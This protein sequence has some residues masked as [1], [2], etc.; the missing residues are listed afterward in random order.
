MQYTKCTNKR[1][2]KSVILPNFSTFTADDAKEATSLAT[3]YQ[4]YVWTY[5]KVKG[6]GLELFLVFT[7]DGETELRD[8]FDGDEYLGDDMYK[9]E[10]VT[11]NENI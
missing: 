1:T 4:V 9:F 5:E 8:V 2:G 3:K 11:N 10:E 7:P 6:E